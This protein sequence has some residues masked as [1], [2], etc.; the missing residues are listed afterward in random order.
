LVGVRGDRK[1]VEVEGQLPLA[2]DDEPSGHVIVCCCCD[3]GLYIFG[4]AK[5][6]QK[7][8]L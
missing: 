5:L 2:S 3:G 6:C 8:V 7:K 4:E 1:E